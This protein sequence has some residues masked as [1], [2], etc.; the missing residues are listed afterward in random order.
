MK[1]VCKLKITSSEVVLSLPCVSHIPHT[2]HLLAH[3]RVR[4][5]QCRCTMSLVAMGV[6]VTLAIPGQPRIVSHAYCIVYTPCQSISDGQG[7]SDR[8]TRQYAW[9]TNRGCPGIVRV[10]LTRGTQVRLPEL[11]WN[12]QTNHE[13]T[14]LH[15]T[16]TV[17]HESLHTQH[18]C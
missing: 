4:D 1:E 10:S 12:F 14:C 6:R 2:A 11:L 16:C 5:V 3:S 8:G 18:T 15:W 7:Y 13:L 9:L 17:C